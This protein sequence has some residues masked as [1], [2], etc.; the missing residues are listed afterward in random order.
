MESY[1]VHIVFIIIILCFWCV[2]NV[3][4]FVMSKFLS[5][6]PRSS[7]DANAFLVND[8]QN[9]LQVRIYYRLVLLV[10]IITTIFLL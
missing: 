10:G 8:F 4:I 2:T 1:C 7:E 6:L 9:P 5:S 3:S